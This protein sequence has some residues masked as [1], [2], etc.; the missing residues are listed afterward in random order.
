MGQQEYR[1]GGKVIGAA[2]TAV[3]ASY[4]YFLIFAQLGF[5]KTLQAATGVTGGTVKPVLGVMGLAGMTGSVAAAWM[6]SVPSSR[7]VLAAGFALC[8]AAAGLSMMATTMIAFYLA[9]LC[10][11]LG[12][13]LTT[14]TLASMLRRAAGDRRLGVIIG[15]GTGLAYGFCNLPAVFGAAANTQAML[16]FFAA[17]AGLAS[18]VMLAPKATAEKPEDFDYSKPGVMIWMLIFLTLVCV[19]SAAFYIIQHTPRLKEETWSNAGQLVLNAVMHLVAALLAGRALDRHW[20][21]KT[22]FAGTVALLM[23]CWMINAGSRTLAAGAMFYSAGVS[24]YS[25]ALVFYPAHSQRPWLAALVYAVAGW[26][27]SA[28]GIGLAENQ[29]EL[30]RGPILVAGAVISLGLLARWAVRRRGLVFDGI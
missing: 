3:A 30:P 20:S 9:A 23:A 5:L 15:L 25:V 12:T 11:G 6:F 1:P 27:G 22:V 24:A 2:I 14:V 17:L 7:G 28:I 10:V 19:D 21:G 4:V 26:G 8:A 29:H 13:G 18:G 16:A